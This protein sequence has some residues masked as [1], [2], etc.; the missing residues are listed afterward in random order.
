LRIKILGA[1]SWGTALALLLA[2]NMHN[3][4]MWSWDTDHAEQLMRDA[5]NKTFL[6]GVALPSDL[7]VTPHISGVAGA[8]VVVFA[9][10]SHAL[11][12]VAEQAKQY[13]KPSTILV[14]TGKGFAP[15]GRRLS[16]VMLGHF[17]N[18][19]YVTLSGPSHAEEVARKL[20]TTVTVSGFDE[21]VS[22][23]VQDI[24]MS[25]YFR[26]YTNKDLI[27]VDL[28]GPVKN[29]NDLAVGI[30]HGMGMGDN[31]KAALVTRGLAEITRL[32][33]ALGA[34]QSTFSG[35]SGVG[36]LFVTCA[37]QHSR[38]FKAGEKIGKGRPWNQVVEEMCMVV[39]G[40]FAAETTYNLAR[41]HGVEM[42][43]TEQ[44]YNILYE[45][46]LPKEALWSL[47]ARSKTIEEIVF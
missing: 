14:N 18:N 24:F 29:I 46:R 37:S 45:G 12:Q 32:G 5:E 27:G 25:N 21:A 47:M 38:N 28:G 40:V 13:I 10:P 30:A 6:P 23:R 9:V 4:S 44:V 11:A 33:M 36:D 1:G 7:L 15:D 39:E 35:L 34:E 16:E 17:P 41:K 2:D 22:Q 42:P 26:V 3:V 20:P 31:A 43:I 19:P 8:D